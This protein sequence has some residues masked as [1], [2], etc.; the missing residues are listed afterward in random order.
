MYI[1]KQNFGLK[2]SRLSN[3]I[4]SKKK[5]LIKRSLKL[6]SKKNLEKKVF[7]VLVRKKKSLKKAK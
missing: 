5:R 6:N 4:Y 1:N 2:I 7:P 3:S